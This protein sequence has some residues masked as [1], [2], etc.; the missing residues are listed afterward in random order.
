MIKKVISTITFAFVFI[1]VSGQENH[2]RPTIEK[3]H[4]FSF[5]AVTLK[6]SWIK[7]REDLNTA[8]LKSIDADRMLHNFRVTAG[9]PSDAQPLEGWESPKVGLRGHFVGHYLSAVSILVNKY[10][11][12]LLS[13]RLK[14]M[15]D[16]LYKCQQQFGNGYLSA[17]PEKDFDT[18][19]SRFGGVWA[20]Y[21]TYNKIMQ[22]LL[23][24]YVYTNNSKA[25]TI[26]LGMADYAAN[27]MSKLSE[28]TIEKMLYT[29][30]ANP[31]NESGAMNEVLYKL[32]KLSNNPKHMELAK[33]FDRD[34]FANPLSLNK[35]VLPGLHSN[36][37]LALVNGFAQ[38]YSITQEK[39]YHDAVVNFWEIL[40]NDHAYANGSSSGPRP[41]VTTSTSLTSEHWGVPRQ[42][43]N[44]L[45]K[46]IAE[47]CVSH[48]TQKLTVHL[49]SWTA[50]PQYADTYMNMFYNAVLPV[51]SPTTGDYV[52][53]LPLGSPRN[54]KYLKHNDF[55][56]CSG[57]SIEAYSQLNSGI[58]YH[59][60]TNLWVNLYI[61]STVNWQEKNVCLEQEGN[62]PADSTI[63]FT[64]SSKKE[65][66]FNLNL[67]IPSWA[68]KADIYINGDKQDLQIEP[69]SYVIL[70]RKWE[71]NDKIKLVFNYDFHIKTMPD[72]DNVFAIFY[73]ATLLAFESNDELI[74]KG[75]LNDILKNISIEGNNVFKLFN[76]GKT[77]I[78]RPLYEIDGQGY[79]VYGE[80]SQ[81]R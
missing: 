26:L 13:D 68:T 43:S 69:L 6:P 8:F 19:E 22:G 40:Q 48:N 42:L 14:Y 47:T 41:N 81:L 11:D 10:K 54:K 61:P 74:L 23:D 38:R 55:A 16:E 2:V 18:L 72:N 70:N 80:I 30:K 46:E 59:D 5:S 29:V 73:G 27:R 21:Y 9:L 20:P 7:H 36:T 65:T 67:L 39:K 24:A 51:Q 62:F 77:Y 53:H 3:V 31:S 79:G 64:I 57:S 4:P 78:L 60:D 71:N 49:F 37:H 1:N 63:E 44:T 35:D 52:Y 32:Y 75:S 50:D 76:G 33:V 66:V 12:P 56:C 15:I 17:F 58:Y 34:W 25:Y 28:E 45:T